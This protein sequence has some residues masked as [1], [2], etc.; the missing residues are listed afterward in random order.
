LP[1]VRTSPVRPPAARGGRAEE[2]FGR[3]DVGAIAFY[4]VSLG[5]ALGLSFWTERART[6]RSAMVGLYLL[7]G[8]PGLLLAI[9]GIASLAYGV[10]DGPLFLA[11]GLALTLPLVPQVRRA[12]ARILP[13][14]PGSPI[15]M[16]GLCFL[17][18]AFAIFGTILVNIGSSPEDLEIESVSL[19]ELALTAAYELGLAYVA[20]GWLVRREMR[21][22]T[23]R[24][25]IRVP[26][27]KTVGIAFGFL[28]LAYVGGA[29]GSILTEVLQP[30][31]ADQIDSVT[32]DL[33]EDV[34]NPV[35]AV[36][37]GACAGIGEE[38]LFRGAIQPRFGIPLTAALFALVH[39]Q[40]GLSYVIVGLFLVG[41]VLGIERKYFGTTAAMITHALFNV[42]AV[43]IQTGT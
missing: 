30:E 23:H 22:A 28:V 39:S 31:L 19:A 11:L 3:L 29:V 5:A 17:L 25:G 21:A 7:F 42:I 35:G 12:L 14:D 37:L 24:L 2:R 43:L 1:A 10:D 16:A 38:A 6:D 18:A 15:D 40:Y 33:T 20:V 8:F 32:D 26:T 13:I 4:L 34:Q 41:V 27:L 36:I 9:W